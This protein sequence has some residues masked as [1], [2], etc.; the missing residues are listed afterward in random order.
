MK[1]LM[2]SWLV[3][4]VRIELF[5]FQCDALNFVFEGIFSVMIGALL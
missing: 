1:D 5:N 3:G 4:V 2:Y